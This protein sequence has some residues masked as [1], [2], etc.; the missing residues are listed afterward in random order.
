MWMILQRYCVCRSIPIMLKHC[1][2]VVTSLKQ[3]TM[4]RHARNWYHNVCR[5]RRSLR[6]RNSRQFWR[7]VYYLFL[8]KYYY[9]IVPRVHQCKLRHYR[10]AL[11]APM[12]ISIMLHY[13][14][15][16]YMWMNCVDCRFEYDFVS[17]CFCFFFFIDENQRNYC[18]CTKYDCRSA[19]RR[20]LGCK[21]AKWTYFLINDFVL[22]NLCFVCFTLYYHCY[23]SI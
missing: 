14:C 5:S 2:W 8:W 9:Y 21:C 3:T 18:C 16:C 20:T 22:L 6:Q 17:N 15:A 12:R 11:V 1:R 13:V 7:F 4:Y 23:S 19:N 10:W